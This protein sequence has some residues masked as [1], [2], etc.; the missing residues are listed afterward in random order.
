ML[1][2]VQW[3]LKGLLIAWALSTPLS[4][5][6]LLRKL[7]ALIDLGLSEFFASVAITCASVLFMWLA[8][9]SI[10]LFLQEVESLASVLMVKASFGVIAYCLAYFALG[11]EDLSRLGRVVRSRGEE[12]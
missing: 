6:F 11:R 12:F 2:G 1:F 7:C 4:Y 3:G 9:A 10:E 5:F 8:V